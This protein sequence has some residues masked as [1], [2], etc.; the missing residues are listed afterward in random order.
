M[1]RCMAVSMLRP[2][3]NHLN[4]QGVFP[5]LGTADMGAG[6][7]SALESVLGAAGA[8]AASLVSTRDG[9]Y[10]RPPA[11]TS[12]NILRHHPVSPLR[13]TGLRSRP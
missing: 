1:D 10:P 12:T 4:V 7:F 11:V 9:R 8:A 2:P 3:L 13:P 5:D 6:S